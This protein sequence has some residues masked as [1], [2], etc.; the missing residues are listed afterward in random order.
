[1]DPSEKGAVSFFLGQAQ[2]KLFAHEFFQVSLLVPDDSYLAH[3]GMRRRRTRPDFIGFHGRNVAI[4]L[5]AKG[6]SPN[7]FNRG[8]VARAKK[9]ASSL[10]GIAGIRVL[11]ARQME[12]VSGDDEVSYLRAYFAEI[13]AHLSV[14]ADI[15]ELVPPDT[16]GI[17]PDT[18]ASRSAA[19]DLYELVLTSDRPEQSDRFEQLDDEYS[20]LGGDGIGIELGPTWAAWAGGDG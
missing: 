9:Q 17:S 2:A 11:R 19:N 14:R 10:P 15:A 8:L 20:F 13:D 18:R 12:R 5:E 4:A 3:L 6:R 16:A 7:G 1:L